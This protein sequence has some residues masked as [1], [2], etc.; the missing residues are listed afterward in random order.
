MTDEQLTVLKEVEDTKKRVDF[1]MLDSRKKILSQVNDIYMHT[2][3]LEILQQ[4]FKTGLLMFLLSMKL[5]KNM[6]K[7]F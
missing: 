5:N 6:R 1:L 4:P 7:Q 2:D 3:S